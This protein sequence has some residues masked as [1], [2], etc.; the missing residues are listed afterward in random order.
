MFSVATVEARLETKKA[1]IV[2]RTARQSLLTA[3]IKNK[4]IALYN[5]IIL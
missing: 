4:K 3:K 1:F 2:F 5:P